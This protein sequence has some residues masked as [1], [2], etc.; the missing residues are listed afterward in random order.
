MA[1]MPKRKT[2]SRGSLP[3][4]EKAGRSLTDNSDLSEVAR[5]ARSR[6]GMLELLRGNFDESE[7][8]WT[9]IIATDTDRRRVDYAR[10]WRRRTELF[11]ASAAETRRC[12]VEA[13]SRFS[14]VA[15]KSEVAENLRGVLANPEYGFRADELIALAKTQG[16][17]LSGVQAKRVKDLSTP[18]IAHYRFKHFV[19]VTGKDRKGQRHGFRSD[20]EP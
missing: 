7:R 11:R 10:N 18:F 12:A 4:N 2:I 17:E 1:G 16:I 3:T 14:Q 19:T 20:P 8:I 6:M 15:G 5:K 13:L 9:E